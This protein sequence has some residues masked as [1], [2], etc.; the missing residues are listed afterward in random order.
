VTIARLRPLTFRI[1]LLW[2]R[3]SVIRHS[4]NNPQFYNTSYILHPARHHLASSS[5]SLLQFERPSELTGLSL[6]GYR[7]LVYLSVVAARY[8][9]ACRDRTVEKLTVKIYRCRYVHY[10][11]RFSGLAQSISARGSLPSGTSHCQ[12]VI[13]YTSPCKAIRCEYW[14][15]VFVL[16]HDNVKQ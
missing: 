8:L 12:K 5:E 1:G 2:V 10:L 16:E 11:C 3:H 4:V 6:A 7:Y 13:V 9:H 14:I 15:A